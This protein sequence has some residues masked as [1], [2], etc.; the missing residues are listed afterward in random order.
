M[1]A[2]VGALDGRPAAYPRRVS[3]FER[4]LRST[5]GEASCARIIALLGLLA[6]VP[7]TTAAA[8]TRSS[9][10]L[11]TASGTAGFGQT[12]NDESS[13]G[14]GLLL[15]GHVER[16][17]THGLSFECGVEWLSHDRG[18]GVFQANGHSTLVNAAL[19]YSWTRTAATSYVLGGFGVARYAATT[20]FED[21]ERTNRAT[22]PGVSVGGGVSFPLR[23]GWRAGPEG[24]LLLFT[25]NTDEAPWLGIYGGVRLAF[26]IGGR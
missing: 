9:G 8:Q 2:C 16:R 11:W 24:R 25:P 17:L 22:L 23:N 10:P 18:D 19:K 4:P 5:L 14:G 26:P 3:Q 7:A 1:T 12:L 20:R 15:A 13:L 6:V 21:V